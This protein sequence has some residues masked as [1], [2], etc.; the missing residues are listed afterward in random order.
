MATVE[1][2]VEKVP[3]PKKPGRPMAEPSVLKHPR[4]RRVLLV[5]AFVL[6]A[7]RPHE[8]TLGLGVT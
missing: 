6:G 7:L 8:R 3:A 5:I 4:F 1:A 2:A